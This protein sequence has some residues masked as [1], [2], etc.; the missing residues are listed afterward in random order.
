MK[1][2]ERTPLLRYWTA[3]YL[4]TLFVGLAIIGLITTLWIYKLENQKRIAIARFVAE[5]ISERI[6]GT[7]GN[8]NAE[9]VL[10]GFLERR[11]HFFDFEARPLLLII[12]NKKI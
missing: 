2:N 12:D 10:S 4:I 6:V 7:K 11:E 9:P 5:D 1:K 8:I 3:R